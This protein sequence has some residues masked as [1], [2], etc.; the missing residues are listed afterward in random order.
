[1]LRWKIDD[2]RSKKPKHQPGPLT[3]AEADELAQHFVDC[4]NAGVLA[5]LPDLSEKGAD[6]PSELLG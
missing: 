4:L 2:G 3:E 1:L 5:D 6:I